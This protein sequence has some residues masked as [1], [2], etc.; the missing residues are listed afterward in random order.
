MEYILI[1][2]RH[3]QAI[4]CQEDYYIYGN[5]ICISHGFPGEMEFSPRPHCM[6]PKPRSGESGIS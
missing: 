5:V 1:D 2:V 3:N 6:L 4:A